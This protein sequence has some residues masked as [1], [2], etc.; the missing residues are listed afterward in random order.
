MGIID[1]LLRFFGDSRELE[2]LLVVGLGE[3]NLVH[4]CLGNFAVDRLVHVD[5]PLEVVNDLLLRSRI[6]ASGALSWP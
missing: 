4:Q 3:P 2:G 5:L 1:D 6:S